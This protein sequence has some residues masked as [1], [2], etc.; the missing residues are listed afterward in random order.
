MSSRRV[1]SRVLP[2]LEKMRILTL[3]SLA[4]V[5]S[6]FGFSLVHFIAVSFVV[7]ANLRT[8]GDCTQNSRRAEHAPDLAA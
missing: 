2:R 1:S 6:P 4:S 3:L 5:G 7:K 8:L